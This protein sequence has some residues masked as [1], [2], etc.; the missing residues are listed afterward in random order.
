MEKD[1]LFLEVSSGRQLNRPILKKVLSL[2]KKGDSLVITK[3]D[4]ISPSIKDTYCFPAE[5]EKKRML[6]DLPFG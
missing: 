2:M 1:C 3:M 6:I 5:L 4:R